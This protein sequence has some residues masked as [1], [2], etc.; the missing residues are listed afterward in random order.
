MISINP[1]V[2][3]K[4]HILHFTTYQT[5]LFIQKYAKVKTT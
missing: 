2:N 5:L 1:Y 4:Q 3:N